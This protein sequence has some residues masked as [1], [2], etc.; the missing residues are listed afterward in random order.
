MW[1]ANKDRTR[2]KKQY[3]LENICIYLFTLCWRW[4]PKQVNI[5]K[6]S[7]ALFYVHPSFPSFY[8]KMIESC[9]LQIVTSTLSKALP[10][11]SKKIFLN[12]LMFFKI[13][14]T[15]LKVLR[16]AVLS[17]RNWL[18]FKS[19]IADVPA[20]SLMWFST[21]EFIRA[22]WSFFSFRT[23]KGRTFFQQREVLLE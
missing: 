4:K 2:A 7:L 14:Y 9:T 20:I 10:W 21:T 1:S 18:S 6:M 22:N 3:N 17:F 23:V 8:I 19:I 15:W 13:C 11:I 5:V 12:S 16:S